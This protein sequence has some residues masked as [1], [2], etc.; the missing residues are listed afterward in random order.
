MKAL[1]LAALLL[2]APLLAAQSSRLDQVLHQMDE[3]SARFRSAEADLK[4][5]SYERVVKDTTTETG[6]VYFLR[7]GAATE[8]GLKMNPPNARF[9]EYKNGVGRIFD[10]GANHLTEARSAQYES[11]LTLGFG[12]RGSDLQK[13]WMVTDQGS[14]Q[15]SDGSAA[16]AVEK[17]DLVARDPNARNTFSHIT[18]WVDPARGVLLKQQFFSPSGDIYTSTYTHIRYNQ[19]VETAPFALK[20]NKSTTVD[21]R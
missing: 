20:T 18:M 7:K 16:V 2:S 8:M 14:E 12:G 13:S 19:K 3:A 1:S 5:E 17:L 4:K 10:P 11:F 15:L 6:S 21:R 9:V